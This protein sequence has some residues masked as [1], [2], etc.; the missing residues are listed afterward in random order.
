MTSG[1]ASNVKY[2]VNFTRRGDASDSITFTSV[3]TDPVTSVIVNLTDGQDYTVY[4]TASVRSC[5]TP[6]AQ[7]NFTVDRSGMIMVPALCITV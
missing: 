6:T 4:I 5:T 2:T 1:C 3:V 7:M